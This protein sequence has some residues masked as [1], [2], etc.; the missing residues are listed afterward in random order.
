MTTFVGQMSICDRAGTA[1]NR[2]ALPETSSD[3][4][5]LGA[6]LA[7]PVQEA[8][9]LLGAANG[10]GVP[11]RAI[12][13][14]A[15]GLRGN[16]RFP[17]ALA[18]EYGDIDLVT[19]KGQGGAV[20]E[21]LGGLGYLAEQRFNA[22][23]GSRRLMFVDERND[24]RL[25]VFVGVF[26]MCH[27]LPLSARIDVDAV[28]VPP[29][30]LLLTKLQVVQLNRKDAGD[31]LALLLVEPLRDD[32]DAGINSAEVARLCAADWGLWRTCKQNL[33][34][35]GEAVATFELGAEA[36]DTARARIAALWAR[37]EAEPKSSKW[38]LR[39]RIGDRKRWYQ[40]PEETH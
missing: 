4:L 3:A 28:T 37:I 30:E 33:E 5:P 26:E 17:M 40:E 14:V 20:S 25:D 21:F 15:I 32:D 9:R 18:R 36:Q 7:D 11:L 2:A 35:L 16:G 34:W 38:R 27:S 1:E 10:A 23:H 12:G 22:L 13:G 8:R 39:H 6:P 29:A 19:A 31:A 24:R